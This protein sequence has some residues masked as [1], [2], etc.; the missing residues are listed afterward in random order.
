MLRPIRYAE[1]VADDPASPWWPEH[2]ARYAW[3]AA[4][5]DGGTVLDLA[6]GSGLGVPLLVAA[7]SVVVALD[8]DEVAVRTA[9]ATGPTAAVV[10]DGGR[11]PFPDATFDAVTSFETIEHVSDAG[12]LLAE[13][14]RVLVP[15][16]TFYGSSPNALI[17]KPIDGVPRN[18]FHLREFTPE[19]FED[20]LRGTFDEVELAGQVT[21]GA[22]GSCAFWELPG[23]VLGTVRL[24]TWKAAHRLPHRIREL[25]SR[26]LLR[27]SFA[28]GT[29]D[30]IF[31]PGGL[32]RAHVIV[33]RC[34]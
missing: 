7:A 30:F 23:G 15:G 18:P 26:A 34:R 32:Q 6:T 24:W 14:R 5:I 31:E 8:L 28:P 16:G 22:Y 19:S 29:D 4:E 21:S 10:A 11:L 1:R 13:I 25:T 3:A 9:K 12:A 17:T 2:R 20:V 33:A 27:R